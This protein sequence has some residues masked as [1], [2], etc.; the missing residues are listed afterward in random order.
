MNCYDPPHNSIENSFAVIELEDYESHESSEQNED[1]KD[2]ANKLNDTV[3]V[4]L[5]SDDNILP[6]PSKKYA[7]NNQSSCQNTYSAKPII[8]S[9]CV[10]CLVGIGLMLILVFLLEKYDKLC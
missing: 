1:T 4:S 3:L 6:K 8:F 5:S 9:C 10:G 7:N 2:M